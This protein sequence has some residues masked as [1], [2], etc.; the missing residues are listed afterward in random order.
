M[1][2]V[3]SFQSREGNISTALTEV[4]SIREPQLNCGVCIELH[5]DLVEWL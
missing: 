3:A 2:R 4:C 5:N 1:K